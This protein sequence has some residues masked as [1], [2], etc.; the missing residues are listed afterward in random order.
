MARH[1]FESGLHAAESGE[2]RV[3]RIVA[4][5]VASKRKEKSG[6]SAA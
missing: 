3:Y 6:R 1:L 5:H 2:Q 4:K